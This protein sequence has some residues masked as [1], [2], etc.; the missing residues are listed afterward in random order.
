MT[1]ILIISVYSYIKK[2]D[3]MPTVI[4]GGGITSDFY[5][6]FLNAFLNFPNFLQ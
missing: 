1:L 2:H 3:K 5:L 4:L 6:V